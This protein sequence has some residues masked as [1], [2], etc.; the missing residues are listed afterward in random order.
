MVGLPRAATAYTTQAVTSFNTN[1][2]AGLGAWEALY[3]GAF[4]LPAS[5]SALQFE[6]VWNFEYVPQEDA[7]IASLAEPQPLF[8]PQMQVAINAVQ[9]AHPPSHKGARAVVGNF[10]KREAK[11][12]LVK[13]VIPFVAKKATQV[14]L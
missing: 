1:T 14:L 13:H 5:T 6:I 3:I 9:S 2:A 12:A 4:G 7:P 10:V 8:D 11:K